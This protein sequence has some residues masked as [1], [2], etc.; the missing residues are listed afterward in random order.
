M[1]LPVIPDRDAI[2]AEIV[3]MTTTPPRQ[4]DEFTVAEFFAS[5]GANSHDVAARKLDK[6]VREGVLE[7]RKTTVD[8]RHCWVYRRRQR[9]H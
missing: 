3:E 8:T 5:G 7:K 2:L 4:P 1:D 6:L 9:P